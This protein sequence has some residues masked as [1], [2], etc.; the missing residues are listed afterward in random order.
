MADR[1]T[2]SHW[3]ARVAAEACRRWWAR[4]AARAL[5]LAWFW[6]ALGDLDEAARDAERALRLA[7]RHSATL[8]ADVALTAARIAQDRDDAVGCRAHLHC[9]LTT[10][11]QAPAGAD[12]DRLRGWAMVGL[13]E[14]HRRAGDYPAAEEVLIR[15]S[16]LVESAEPPDPVLHAAVLTS[17][18]IAAKELGAFDAAAQ[19]Y[20]RVSSIHDVNGATPADAATLAHNLAGLHYARGDC[21]QSEAHARRAL[22]LRRQQ[23]RVTELDLAADLAVLASALAGQRC[24]DE[25]RGLLRR[26]LAAYQTA[27]PPRRYEIAVQWHNLA[28]VEH[29]EGRLAQAED[30]Y[31]RALSLKEQLFG[32]D[33]PEVGLLANNLGT[34]LMDRGRENDAT[35][36]YRRALAVLERAYPSGHPAIGR[37]RRNM[38]RRRSG[39]R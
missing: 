39:F 24:Y 9:A 16:R 14:Q 22:A 21:A 1:R 25:A 31:R 8:V 34:L 20:A 13:G 33:H 35:E 11:E 6:Q 26:A 7:R 3:P 10:L 30:L 15:A 18:G 17:Q 27:R 19:C 5:R 37:V 12:R 29:A 36:C 23:P 38:N 2:P 32:T 4:R 28:D